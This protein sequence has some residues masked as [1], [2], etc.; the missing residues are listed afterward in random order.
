MTNFA[1]TKAI[2]FSLVAIF[3]SLVE[4]YNAICFWAKILQEKHNRGSKFQYLVL[5]FIS[6][7][8]FS[9]YIIAYI[10]PTRNPCCGRSPDLDPI[11][12]RG[13]KNFYN[14]SNPGLGCLYLMETILSKELLTIIYQLF[15]SRSILSRTLLA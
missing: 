5:V 4:S 12:R 6:I 9:K 7:R 1:A 8:N 11:E 13:S 15:T 2:F 14:K 3:F 10:T